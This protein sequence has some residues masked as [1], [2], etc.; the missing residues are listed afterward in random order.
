MAVP[1]SYHTPSEEIQR[2]LETGIGVAGPLS[3]LR[4]RNNL[5]DMSQISHRHAGGSGIIH[6]FRWNSSRMDEA[7]R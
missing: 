1:V 7:A 3:S 2:S 5:R 4:E 6:P